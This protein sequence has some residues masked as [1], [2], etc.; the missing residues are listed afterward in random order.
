MSSFV[1]DGFSCLN[2][3]QNPLPLACSGD[4]AISVGKNLADA[5]PVTVPS[6]NTVGRAVSGGKTIYYAS[7]DGLFQVV[8]GKNGDRG[9]NLS[10]FSAKIVNELIVTDGLD[11]TLE[12]EI[13]A[14]IGGEKTLIS[15]PAA[16]FGSMNWVI[17]KLGGMA[18]MNPGNTVRDHV[19]AAIQQLSGNISKVV[20]YT[21]TGWVC[22]N[23]SWYFLHVDGAIGPENKSDPAFVGSSLVTLDVASRI[24][25]APGYSCDNLKMKST[26]AGA[27]AD[28]NDS[29]VARAEA[30][31]EMSLPNSLSGK[32]MTRRGSVGTVEEH[33]SGSDHIRVRLTP[34][35]QGY[36]LPAPPVGQDLRDAILASFDFLSIAPDRLS[37]PLFACIWTAVLGSCNFTIQLVGPTHVGKTAIAALAQQFFG[38]GM[39]ETNLPAAWAS[40]GNAITAQ[41]F[42]AKDV[43]LVVDDLVPAGSDAERANR[44]AESVIRAQGNHVGRARSRGDGSLI[45]GKASRCLILSTGEGLPDGASLNSR[46]LI[47]RIEQEDV[48]WKLVTTCQNHANKGEFAKA[49][50]GF[51]QWMATDHDS[52]IRET[53]KQ[54]E[55][56]HGIFSQESTTSRTARIAAI[57]ISGFENFL[58][59]ALEHKVIDEVK[60]HELWHKAEKALWAAI[61]VHKFDQMQSDPVEQFRQLL[62]AAFHGGHAYVTGQDGQSPSK[63]PVS[64]GWEEVRHTFPVA[65]SNAT[66]SPENDD[67]NSD[68]E[69]ERSKENKYADMYMKETVTFRHRGEQVGYLEFDDLY[70]VPALVVKVVQKLAKTSSFPLPIMA[71]DLGSKLDAAGKLKSKRKGRKTKQ[72]TVGN[73]QVS[74][75]HVDAT[76]INPWKMDELT[77]EEIQEQNDAFDHLLYA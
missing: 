37:F 56:M 11:K 47:L 53:Q 74:V 58:D 9:K 26:G 33:N 36:Q 48:D 59:F 54:I 20:V 32:N 3:S 5:E 55:K 70:L 63:N 43:V 23:E 41:A 46:S 19:R 40:T 57:L 60:H 64:W 21:H 14:E 52:I 24:A 68:D 62:A 6:N 8:S 4:S 73:A 27:R 18:V 61:D 13:E 72:I 1:S 75:L 76:W 7:S 38:R 69:T 50:A 39:D 34:T 2:S 71:Y 66:E 42:L 44:K 29:R 77:E 12:F 30:S 28:G 51:L 15:I 65:N 35:L 49:M 17:T 31:E 22:H 67:A 10:N 16:E 25:D 45:A